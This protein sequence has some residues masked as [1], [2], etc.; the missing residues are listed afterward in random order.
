[1]SDS[2][3][4][5]LD[6]D[7]VMER[8]EAA[9]EMFDIGDVT[10]TLAEMADPH[11]FL[12]TDR[13][14]AWLGRHTD[15]AY[16]TE[17]Y[18]GNR[19]PMELKWCNKMAFAMLDEKRKG[20][21][22]EH[23]ESILEAEFDNGNGP[24]GAYDEQYRRDVEAEI[25]RMAEDVEDMDDAPDFDAEEWK[26]AMRDRIVEHMAENDSSSVLDM[27]GS[28]DRCEIVVRFSPSND[29]IECPSQEF[30]RMVIDDAL[31]RTLAGLGYTV[32]DYRR[33][34]G[35]K[36]P[37]HSLKGPS[38]QPRRPQPLINEEDF[39]TLVAE[40][41]ASTF[42]IVL[43][44]IVPLS[45]I[46][47]LDLTKPFALDGYAIASYNS[48]NGTF[49]DIRRREAVTIMPGEGELTGVQGYAPENICGLHTPDYH[50]RISNV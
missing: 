13:G 5:M 20:D 24:E 39:R 30:D 42:N 18:D 17:W 11:V 43:Y 25:D 50:A 7:P 48:N 16:Y 35:S 38:K 23:A 10:M 40:S 33:M 12:E 29:P 21:A 4:T 36:K 45:D 2:H 14:K 31:Q 3:E 8:Q 26:E 46:V 6:E 41:Y 27:I 37:S 34:S 49:F 15:A 32:S 28:Y 1:M 9:E 44:A 22:G 47:A 19:S